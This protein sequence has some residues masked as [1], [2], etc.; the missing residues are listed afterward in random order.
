MTSSGAFFSNLATVSASNP[1]STGDAGLMNGYLLLSNSESVTLT[2]IAAWA[3]Y[4]YR[5]RAFF[6]IG[7]FTRNYGITMHDGGTPQTFWT[8]DT[9]GTDSDTN[10][11]GIITWVETSATT[12]GTAV[13]DANTALF[14]P[15]TGNTLTISGISPA[16]RAALNGLQIIPYA[17]PPATIV[18]FTATPASFT[19][20]QSVT[21]N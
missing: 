21:L 18:S 2:G 1:T 13:A 6:D 19:A 7:A 15:F 3:P 4:G 17:T 12:E 5:V 10:N 11:D 8:A 20:G 9:L 16:T 14:G